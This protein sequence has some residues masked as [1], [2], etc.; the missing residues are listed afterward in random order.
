MNPCRICQQPVERLIDFGPQPL[1]NRFLA[2]ASAAEARHPLRLGQ[3]TACGLLQLVD[4]VAAAA[5]KPPAP[6]LYNEPEWH[7]DQVAT[8]ITALAGVTR[9]A[10]ICGA[11]Y[12]DASMID[13]LRRRGYPNAICL[14][15]CR[16]WGVQDPA[17]GIETLQERISTGTL[18]DLPA[19]FGRYQVVIA[20][21]V[22]EH[23][24]VP[25][26]FVDGLTSLLAADGY[27]IFEVP[28]F[29]GSVQSGNY[30]TIWEEHVTYLTK[31]TFPSVLQRLGLS[32]REVLAF[33]SALEDLLVGVTQVA[34]GGREPAPDIRVEEELAHGRHYASMVP[35]VRSVWSQ[36]LA[37]E[38]NAGRPVVL[39][40][41]GHLAIMFLNLLELQDMVDFVVDDDAT[42]CGSYLPGSRLPVCGSDAL[43]TGR[44][45][46]CLMSVSPENEGKVQQR[47]RRFL[48]SG[49]RFASIFPNSQLALVPPWGNAS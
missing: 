31:T 33:P 3:C 39:L 36:A 14:D 7:L 11:T 48:E 41:A 17:A 27:L 45:K 40:G 43:Y 38:R 26:R 16:D 35:A 49:G 12:K 10:G 23:A 44:A 29:T 25:Q 21:H 46:L 20:R 15:A 6:I 19:H 4:P 5:V 34:R 28:D 18:N 13:R 9:D 37:R 47:H 32:V 30:S 22:F 1:C 42:K 8:R 2:E 24:H